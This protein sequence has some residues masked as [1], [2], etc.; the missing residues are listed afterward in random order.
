MNQPSDT[1]QSNKITNEKIE[2][3]KK[4]LLEDQ[5]EEASPDN[6]YLTALRKELESKILDKDYAEF[7][8]RIIKRTVR[9][10]DS[11]V[12]QIFYTAIS[13][14]STNPINLAVLAPTSEG[15][16]Y[17]VLESLQYFPKQ[18][19][20]KIGSMSPKVIIRQNGILVDSNNQPVEDKIKEL[21]RKIKNAKNNSDEKEDLEQE[22]SHLYSEAKVLIDLRG[23]LW[24]FLEPPHSETWTILK[25][26]L[27]HDDFEIEHPYVYEVQGMGFKV[28]KVVTRGWLACIFCSAKNESNWPAWPEIQSRFLITSPNMIPQKYLDGNRLIAQKMGLPRL[29]QQSII[30][31]DDQI[32][33]A[34]KCVS[35][36]LQQIKER[37]MKNTKDSNNINPIWVPYAPILAEILPA[38]KGA[39]NRTTR[40]ILSF[41][42]T[43]TLARAHL[44]NRL[45]YGDESLP[46][47]DL[48]DLHEVLH[49][50]QNLSGIPPYKLKVF[51]E[52][53][54]EKYN[55]KEFRDKSPDGSKEERRIG[56]TTRELCDHYRE[57]TGKTI[58]T[59]NM[60]QSLVNEF[61]NNGLADEEDSIIDGRQKI[62]YPLIDFPQEDIDKANGIESTEKIT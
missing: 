62:Y 21:K 7:I 30:I 61:I 51:K 43:I 31:S 13:K 60:K 9:R 59:N 33:L 27:S 55:S 26:I 29:L 16:T 37:F 41:L 17:P 28:K 42:T 35:F 10:E 14:D 11:L 54:I 12:R 1:N 25:P 18:D 24:V 32:E 48:E 3:I 4:K 15:K 52:V 19:I 45:E 20:W 5:N 38:E 53:F 46:I 40:R 57:K 56:V 36:I 2:K 58:T 8:V 6:D 50:T 47:A 49:I 34:K 44:R 23:K 22:L 39:D